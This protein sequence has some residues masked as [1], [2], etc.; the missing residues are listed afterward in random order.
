MKTNVLIDAGAPEFESIVAETMTSS[1]EVGS[2]H[3][4]VV[5]P[6]VVHQ[7]FRFAQL[8][9]AAPLKYSVAHQ[10]LLTLRMKTRRGRM[11]FFCI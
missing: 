2:D 11:Y 9:L 5:K 6:L 10:A 3:G 7:L 1:L 4:W 8:P